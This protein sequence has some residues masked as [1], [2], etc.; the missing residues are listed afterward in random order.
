MIIGCDI[1]GVLADVKDFAYI[2]PDWDE[3]F[4]HTLEFPSIPEIIMLVNSLTQAGHDVVYI[5]GRPASNRDDTVLWLTRYI[6]NLNPEKI[7]MRQKGDFR[8]SIDIKLEVIRELRPSFILE[9]EPKAVDAIRAE[10]FT[11]L[12]VHG[13][14]YSGEDHI[15][16]MPLSET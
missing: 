13:Y 7:R 16:F 9:D 12:Q 8:Q 11:V 10:G 14:R 15:P 4:R 1:D 5:T 6:H 3:Y 2:L